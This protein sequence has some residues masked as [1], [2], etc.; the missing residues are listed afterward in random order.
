MNLQAVKQM[1]QQVL[2]EEL[3]IQDATLLANSDPGTTVSPG[4][5]LAL[6]G[7]VNIVVSKPKPN[8]TQRLSVKVFHQ[9]DEFIM[10]G[11]IDPALEVVSLALYKKT[12]S[13]IFSIE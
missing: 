7:E 3:D 11:S 13:R 8:G 4:K 12:G 5:G 2:I 6:T 9:E 1:V 10:V